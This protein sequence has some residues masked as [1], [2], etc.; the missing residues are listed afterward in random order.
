MSSLA[1]KKRAEDREETMEPQQCHN[2][3]KILHFSSSDNKCLDL[4]LSVKEDSLSDHFQISDYRPHTKYG[5][6]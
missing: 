1:C 3:V 4:L 2:T 6:R 5:G